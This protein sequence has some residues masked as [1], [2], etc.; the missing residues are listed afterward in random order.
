MNL[1]SEI[2]VGAPISMKFNL[3][4]NK[5]K[6]TEIVYGFVVGVDVDPADNDVVRSIRINQIIE[7]SNYLEGKVF[8]T[9]ERTFYEPKPNA[10]SLGFIDLTYDTI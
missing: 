10:C 4:A 1:L 6:Y 3:T 7:F 5:M 2:K 9:H 8:N